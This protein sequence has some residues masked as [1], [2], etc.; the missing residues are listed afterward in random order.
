MFAALPAVAD[1]TASSATVLMYQNVAEESPVATSVRPEGFEQHLDYLADNGYTVWPLPRLVERLAAGEE[2]PENTVA[3]TFDDAHESVYKQAWPRLRERGWPFTVFVATDRA[4]ADPYMTWDE[5]RELADGDAVIANHSRSHGHLARP[6]QNES[7]AEW[8]DRLRAEIEGAQAILQSKVG[9]VSRLF[10][11]PYGEFS[12]RSQALLD[13]LGYAGFGQQPGAV[14]ADSDFTALPR[15]TMAVGFDDPESFALKVGS[16]PLPVVATEPASGVLAAD[17]GELEL[18]L[19]LG[20]GDYN[21]EHLACFSRGRTLERRWLNDTRTR[22]QFRDDPIEGTGR[23]RQVCT[24]PARD[25]DA[26]YWF[27]FQW[28]MPNDDGTWYNG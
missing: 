15:F 25:S 10:A 6:R 23:V 13:E 1:S 14:G 2:V 3:I 18:V 19:E 9:T 17:A 8:L 12:P 21:K 4:G 22:V 28:M 7:G 24:A 26:W 5:L 27:S 20:E 11:W 16:R